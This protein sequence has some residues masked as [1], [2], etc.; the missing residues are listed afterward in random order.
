MN[1]QNTLRISKGTLINIMITG[2]AVVLLLSLSLFV[3]SCEEDF[4]SPDGD[5]NKSAIE[6][7]QGETVGGP[8]ILMGVDPEFDG[9]HN[10]GHGHMSNWAE[11]VEEGILARISNGGSGILVI[12]MAPANSGVRAYWTELGNLTGQNVAF[13]QDSAEIATVNFSGYAMIGVASS[14]CEMNPVSYPSDEGLDNAGN[15]ALVSRAADVAGFVNSGGGLLGFTQATREASCKFE[16]PWGYIGDLGDFET[17]VGLCYS[18]IVPTDEG[19]E[20]KLT[21]PEFSFSCWHDVFTSGPDFLDVLAWRRGYEGDL[22]GVSADNIPTGKQAAALGGTRVILQIPEKDE[23]EPEEE[24]EDPNDEDEPQD[25]DGEPEVGNG[26][27]VDLIA[28]QHHVAGE[29]CVSNDTE[30]LHVTYTTTDGWMLSESHLAI[31]SDQTGSGE[32]INRNNRWQNRNGNPA[33]GR[34]PYSK[35]HNSNT[36][37][38][39]TYIIPLSDISGGV[40]DETKLYLGTHAVIANSQSAE[41]AWGDGNRM[42]QRG[43]WAMYFTYTVN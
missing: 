6:Y 42:V 8:V 17:Q 11:L 21:D 26:N 3:S 35:K 41:S 1:L 33:P 16:N 39:Y 38:T 32:W 23:K 37:Y 20:V 24:P 19:N 40:D 36:D 28:G 14:Y 25:P 15:N 34:F 7:S 5:N 10:Q 2:L 12:G 4:T 29:V 43:N 22:S 30:N 31:S 18:V 9:A 27:C 13:A